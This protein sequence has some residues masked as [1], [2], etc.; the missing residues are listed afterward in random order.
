MDRTQVVYYIDYLER[1]IYPSSHDRDLV[2]EYD[3][4]AK[5]GEKG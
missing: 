4:S 3:V 5:S 1:N 2:L